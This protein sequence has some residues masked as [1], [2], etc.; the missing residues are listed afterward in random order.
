LIVVAGAH[1][2]GLLALLMGLLI[3]APPIPD[4]G[5]ALIG[6]AAGVAGAGGLAALY[7]GMSLGSMAMV[8]SL[9]GAGSLAIPL[10]AGAAFGASVTP[11]QLAGVACVA[12][13]GTAASG[14][15]RDEVGRQALLLAAAAAIGFGTW[16]V[17]LDLAA[18]SGDPLWALV[19]SRATSAS[20]ATAF[21]LG[22]FDRSRFPF[23]IVIAAGLFD[24]GGNALYVVAR[25]VIPI[26]LAAAL[27]GLYP[28][29]TMIL[30]R[31]VLGE[32]LPR[33]GQLGVAFALLGIVLISAG[34]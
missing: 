14:A 10:V 25:E 9:S 26:G 28:V 29:V 8:T 7:R 4:L 20:L 34:G 27:T 23:R 21:A 22:R 3:L 2:V 17:L 1:F 18:R 12:A 15:S 16:Y 19:F 32:R 31:V 24:V 5:P 13:A 6:V 30:A 11:L 33:L